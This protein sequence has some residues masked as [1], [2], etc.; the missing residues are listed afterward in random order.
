M[1][2]ADKTEIE[3]EVEKTV[4]VVEREPGVVL[5]LTQAEARALYAVTTRVGGS[6]SDSP[7]RHIDSIRHALEDP[8]RD[9][10][11]RLSHDDSFYPWAEPEVG[12]MRVGPGLACN[13]YPEAS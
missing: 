2:E 13:D 12:L 1:A 3:T 10:S 7:R 5:V 8:L 6:P 4:T 11:N 9:Y